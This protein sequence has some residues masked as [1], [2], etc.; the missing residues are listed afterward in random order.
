MIDRQIDN[1]EDGQIRK[2]NDKQID[3]IKDGQ[4]GR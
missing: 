2:V 1:K 4:I 3:N